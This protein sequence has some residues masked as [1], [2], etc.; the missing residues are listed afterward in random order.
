[1]SQIPPR[2][3]RPIPFGSERSDDIRR[4]LRVSGWYRAISPLPASTTLKSKEWSLQRALYCSEIGSVQS[5]SPPKRLRKRLCFGLWK[6]TRL[7]G[8]FRLKM[9]ELT[10]TCMPRGAIGSAINSVTISATPRATS[11]ATSSLSASLTA[12]FD[13]GSSSTPSQLRRA[14]EPALLMKSALLTTA[15]RKFSSSFMRSTLASLVL[16]PVRRRLLRLGSVPIV[17]WIITISS[18]NALNR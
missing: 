15:Q 18:R 1:M 3:L 5:T 12:S 7:D 10:G 2:L 14:K 11:S 4:K 13:S 16:Q 9:A 8:P 6:A 17:G